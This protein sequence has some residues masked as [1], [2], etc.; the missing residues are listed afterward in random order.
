MAN[1]TL[2]TQFALGLGQGLF[3]LSTDTV[4]IALLSSTYVPDANVN[5]T[6]NDVSS[7]EVIG[8]GYA[9]GGQVVTGKLWTA[10]GGTVSFAAQSVLWPGATITARYL[11]LV[12]RAGTGLSPSDRLICFRDLTGGG[13]ASSNGATFQVN[14]NGS[15]A[16]SANTVF[17]LSHTP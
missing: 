1:A 11:V 5:A 9:Q 14:F 6:W 15:S 12:R 3:N 10:V 2:Y 17:T 16:S 8:S 13:D 7:Y 4:Q